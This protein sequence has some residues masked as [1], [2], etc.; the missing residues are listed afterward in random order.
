MAPSVATA[1]ISCLADAGILAEQ[2]IGTQRYQILEAPTALEPFISLE[3]SLANSTD[4][5]APEALVRPVPQSPPT[6][7]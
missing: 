7:R 5:T 3:R 1:A 6:R 2:D 4:A